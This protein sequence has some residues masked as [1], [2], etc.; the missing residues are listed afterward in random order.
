MLD[1]PP[2]FLDAAL[3]APHLLEITE[4]EGLWTFKLINSSFESEMKFR[5]RLAI[6]NVNIIADI[7]F[8]SK[9]LLMR[10]TLMAEKCLL[11]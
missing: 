4:D 11:Q 3:S 1:M 10:K 6:E 2:E 7:F 9:K 8:S 5:V